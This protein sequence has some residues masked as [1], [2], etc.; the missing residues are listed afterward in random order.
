MVT[1]DDRL[2][3]RE[4]TTFNFLLGQVLSG[5]RKTNGSAQV[6]DVHPWCFIPL[7]F[8]LTVLISKVLED[9]D[10]HWSDRIVSGT[11]YAVPFAG[12]ARISSRDQC[13]P[14]IDKMIATVT[15]MNTLLIVVCSNIQQNAVG[16]A[17]K[18]IHAVLLTPRNGCI[19]S[20]CWPGSYGDDT[21]FW[22]NANKRSF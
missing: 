19:Q 6:H 18:K 13:F 12:T 2:T 21:F 11:I 4:C 5:H 1:T 22:N 10:R 9:P 14:L 8:S 20:D 16:P 7:F 3:L 17:L 15:G